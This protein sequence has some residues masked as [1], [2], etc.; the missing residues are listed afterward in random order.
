M[1]LPHHIIEQRA[2]DWFQEVWNSYHY[3]ANIRLARGC[4]I[5]V[6]SADHI[7]LKNIDALAPPA[8]RGGY[9]FIYTG[10][11]PTAKLEIV[12]N[13]KINPIPQA[14]TGEAAIRLSQIDNLDAR[15]LYVISS[16]YKQAIQLARGGKPDL[17]FDRMRITDSTI[18][19]RTATTK[20]TLDIGGIDD[21]TD[22]DYP[23]PRVRLIELVRLT[24]GAIHITKTEKRHHRIA[25][26]RCVD[27][28]IGGKPF[29]GRWTY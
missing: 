9:Y 17:C 20:A 29:N 2:T 1:T 22:K 16:G 5:K 3:H 11:H 12:N 24:C 10:D 18:I 26:I 13:G 6:H 21:E 7:V 25:T 28:I 14:T 8:A 27:C 4:F 15:G 19:G 23:F